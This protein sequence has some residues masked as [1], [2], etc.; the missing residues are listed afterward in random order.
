MKYE[1]EYEY[2]L[3]PVQKTYMERL[4]SETGTPRGAENCT[5]YR[6]QEG[7]L[8]A[9]AATSNLGNKVAPPRPG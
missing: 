3:P 9:N 2:W 6:A 5:G 7:G 4:F 1:Y 8:R